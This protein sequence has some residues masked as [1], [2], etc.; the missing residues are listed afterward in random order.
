VIQSLVADASDT[1]LFLRAVPP[2][3]NL[4]STY[5]DA[6]AATSKCVHQQS[7]LIHVPHTHTHTTAE[8]N[9]ALHI[10]CRFHASRLQT[11]TPSK[12]V[13]R[14]T[15]SRTEGERTEERTNDDD[16]DEGRTCLPAVD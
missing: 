10:T 12:C 13:A 9:T 15:S 2:T 7:H 6:T 3:H 1:D 16:D 11:R 8:H 4:R 14:I 5:S